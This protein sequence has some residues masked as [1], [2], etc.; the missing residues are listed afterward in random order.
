MDKFDLDND[1]LTENDI[2]ED[3]SK[4]DENDEDLKKDFGL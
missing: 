4:K 3:N 1:N 2:R